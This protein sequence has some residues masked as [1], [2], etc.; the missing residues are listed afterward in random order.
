M[1]WASDVTEIWH[2]DKKLYICVA[3]DLFSRKVV[4]WRIG[5][6]NNTRLT[7]GAFLLAFTQRG[8]QRR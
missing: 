5:Q 2:K 3:I 1:I 6:F 7:L 8:N 4:S